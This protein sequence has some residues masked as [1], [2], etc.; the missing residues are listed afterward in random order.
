MIMNTIAKGLELF[1]LFLGT[2]IKFFITKEIIRPK[3][4]YEG[5]KKNLS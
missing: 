2:M 3:F 5:K 4:D 1:F